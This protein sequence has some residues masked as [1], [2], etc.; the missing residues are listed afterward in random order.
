MFGCAAGRV[1]FVFCAP[2]LE[3]DLAARRA[4]FGVGA[5]KDGAG[6]KQVGRRGGG[7]SLWHAREDR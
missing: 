1:R 4:V 5:D 2:L 7:A 3:V 6:E